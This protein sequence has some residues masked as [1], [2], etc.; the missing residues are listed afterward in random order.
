LL[1]DTIPVDSNRYTWRRTNKSP[2]IKQQNNVRQI[3]IVNWFCDTT[4]SRWWSQRLSVVITT[5]SLTRNSTHQTCCEPCEPRSISN[6]QTFFLTKNHSSLLITPGLSSIG[7]GNTEALVS[8]QAKLIPIHWSSKKL[9]QARQ[10]CFCTVTLRTHAQ[11]SQSL[12]LQL[13]WQPIHHVGKQDIG[14]SF[15]DFNTFAMSSHGRIG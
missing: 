5:T 3:A 4:N 10:G 1:E 2:L 11:T 7:Q 13:S 8:H 6:H 12:T 9:S 15:L 14:S